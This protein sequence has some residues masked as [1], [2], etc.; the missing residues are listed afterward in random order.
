MLTKQPV[1][2]VNGQLS[3]Y[4]WHPQ[5][6]PSNILGDAGV[7]KEGIEFIHLLMKP[8]PGDR[9]TAEAAIEHPWMKPLS[10][11]PSFSDAY[12]SVRETTDH[13]TVQIK[14]EVTQSDYESDSDGSQTLR[15]ATTASEGNFMNGSVEDYCSD[16]EAIRKPSRPRSSE[17]SCLSVGSSRG[18]K[19]RSTYTKKPVNENHV[20]YDLGHTQESEN[21]RPLHPK[22]AYLKRASK[23]ASA[24][25]IFEAIIN[26]SHRNPDDEERT[27]RSRHRS[28]SRDS[29]A[30]NAEPQQ[31]KS[32]YR[33]T[34]P[35]RRDLSDESS[36]HPH[37]E[38]PWPRKGKT[39][40]PRKWLH[41][42]AVLDLHYPLK[43]EDDMI[44]IQKALS[45]E[46]ID[47]LIDLSKSYM[48]QPESEIAIP[49]E[50]RYLGRSL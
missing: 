21:H 42:H 4:V 25:N 10:E 43:D 44:I 40:I 15:P 2:K 7:D 23:L 19:A 14:T 22:R 35:I 5:N 9:L 45:T 46:Q 28:P 41:V 36:R 20:R 17:T 13:N 8:V 18:S 34:S 11:L 29:E 48:G 50:G 49:K 30:G 24:G 1:F 37:E 47:E 32:K 31:Q 27:G 33:M 26:R 12:D 6:F 39:R 3:S 38:K 16:D